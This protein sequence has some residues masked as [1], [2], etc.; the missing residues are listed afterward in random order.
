MEWQEGR[1]AKGREKEKGEGRRG[2]EEGGEAYPL[3][4][5][6]LATALHT[7]VLICH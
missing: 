2:R 5:K 4:M 7:V 6:I 3:R 1:G